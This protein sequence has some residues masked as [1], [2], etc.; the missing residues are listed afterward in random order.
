MAEI[1]P[2]GDLQRARLARL[3]AEIVFAL[4]RGRDAPPLLFD[5]AVQ[6]EALDP[7]AARETY[8]EAIGAA[9]FAG[10]LYADSGVR[11]AAKAA[12]SAPPPPQPPRSID[13]VLDGM[14][15]WFTER[16]GVGAPHVAARA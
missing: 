13:L 3:R 14:A 6:L 12:R 10:R 9:M 15:A 2:L 1:C 8:V 16:P 4:R 7:A 5:A 11:K